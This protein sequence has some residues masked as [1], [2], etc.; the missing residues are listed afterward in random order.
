MRLS[1]R[2]SQSIDFSDVI[3]DSTRVRMCLDQNACFW[4]SLNFRELYSWS[5]LN[6][7]VQKETEGANYT[8]STLLSGQLQSGILIK[9]LSR[10]RCRLLLLVGM[11][12]QIASFSKFA[13]V[14]YRREN[15][16]EL[17]VRKL[18]CSAVMQTFYL[19]CTS[20]GRL[21]EQFYQVSN[22][23]VTGCDL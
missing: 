23:N 6:V 14:W 21:S 1:L 12:S 3:L 20:T 19:I 17:T 4:F 10:R 7:Y 18:L 2:P 16:L 22:A 13:A 11:E 9:Q 8:W 5:F 15:P